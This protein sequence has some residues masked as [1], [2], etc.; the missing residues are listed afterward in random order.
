M[1]ARDISARF[2]YI[3]ICRTWL[4]RSRELIRRCDSAI[5]GSKSPTESGKVATFFKRRGWPSFANSDC[6]A[7][8][9][10][11]QVV[12]HSL[13]QLR[14]DSRTVVPRQRGTTGFAG[15]R[16]LV[17][18]SACSARLCKFLHSSVTRPVVGRTRGSA[19]IGERRYSDAIAIATVIVTTTTQRQNDRSRTVENVCHLGARATNPSREAEII[20]NQPAR[21]ES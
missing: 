3:S 21:P 10:E 1:S 12:V 14:T 9:P 18:A 6:V 16:N 19:R 15:L 13:G 4:N 17:R 20:S 5:S 2:I 11:Q 8:F 7:G